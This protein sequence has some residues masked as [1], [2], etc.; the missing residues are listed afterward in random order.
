MT[1]IP[2]PFASQHGAQ[3]LKSQITEEIMGAEVV[4]PQLDPSRVL[5]PTIG[6]NPNQAWANSTFQ[7]GQP[8]T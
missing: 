3:Q 8:T 1:Y 5:Q 2:A 6:G 4:D 7:C